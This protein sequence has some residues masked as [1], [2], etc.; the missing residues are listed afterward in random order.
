MERMVRRVHDAID[1]NK[2]GRTL[3]VGG[4]VIRARNAIVPHKRGRVFTMRRL[5]AVILIA[6]IVFLAVA[7]IGPTKS[8][9][10]AYLERNAT[11]RS[12]DVSIRSAVRSSPA[13]DKLVAMGYLQDGPRA[14]AE[15]R[16]PAAK[17]AGR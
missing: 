16:A 8:G 17:P 15:A 9:V 10:D 3:G 11:I 1:P 13:G 5:V 12:L 14:A 2:R 4:L 6:G 7:I